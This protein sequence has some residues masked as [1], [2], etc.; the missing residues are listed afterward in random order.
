M[1]KAKEAKAEDDDKGKGK[2]EDA[3]GKLGADGV[4]GVEGDGV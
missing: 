3:K 4:L 2:P 1:G